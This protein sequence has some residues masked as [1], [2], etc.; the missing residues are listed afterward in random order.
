VRTLIEYIAK[1]VSSNVPLVL[2]FEPSTPQMGDSVSV[3]VR[4]L[5]ADTRECL[6]SASSSTPTPLR[7]LYGP[8]ARV[9]CE[10]AEVLNF[11]GEPVGAQF[12]LQ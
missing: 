11:T 5:L 7:L 1:D 10:R 9:R 6:G 2:A 4:A 8:E 12:T 3:L